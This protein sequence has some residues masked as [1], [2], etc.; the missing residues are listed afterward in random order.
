[1][2]EIGAG[3]IFPAT[4]LEKMENIGI[5]VL[6]LIDVGETKQAPLSAIDVN[7]AVFEYKA[8]SKT[9]KPKKSGLSS[10]LFFSNVHETGGTA[11]IVHVLESSPDELTG[12]TPALRGFMKEHNVDG[13]GLEIA[14]PVILNKD[15]YYRVTL[16]NADG[17]DIMYTTDTYTVNGNEVKTPAFIF[18]LTA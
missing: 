14:S 18:I 16:Y 17:G 1:M 9:F 7:N 13:G 11:D 12:F 4:L 5:D 15:L 10:M 2:S 3:K 8:A 6:S